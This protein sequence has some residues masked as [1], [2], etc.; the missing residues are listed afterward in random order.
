MP[1]Y[2]S[3]GSSGINNS[4]K[5]NGH[6]NTVNY[7]NHNISSPQS[8]IINSNINS[9]TQVNNAE[10]YYSA[11]NNA[12]QEVVAEKKEDIKDKSTTEKIL[13]WLNDNI[14][15]PSNEV[16]TQNTEVDRQIAEQTAGTVTAVTVSAVEGIVDAF[17]GMM[18]T[19]AKLGEYTML[20]AQQEVERQLA[21]D[22]ALGKISVEER[23][24][25]SAK[26]AQE[27]SE[28]RQE[29]HDYVQDSAQRV[30]NFKS[31][32]IFDVKIPGTETT[33][34]EYIIEYS[35]IQEDSFA[36]QVGQSIGQMIP[37]IVSNTLIPGSGTAVFATSCFGKS[38]SAAY[39]N[40]ANEEEAL[41]YAALTTTVEV[42][43][44]LIPGNGF[45]GVN[46]I[47]KIADNNL[48]K[49]VKNISN[50]ETV[51]KVVN[52][53]FTQFIFNAASEGVEEVISDFAEPFILKVS[54]LKEEDL[55]NLITES[56][57]LE[58]FAT[59]FLL[60]AASSAGL[61]SLSTATSIVSNSK[62]GE[63]NNISKKDL[64]E[65]YDEVPDSVKEIIEKT[66]QRMLEDLNDSTKVS[67]D[68]INQSINEIAK[69]GGIISSIF[70]NKITTSNNSNQNSPSM[71]I[72]NKVEELSN[73][74]SNRFST[75]NN[76]FIIDS[77]GN[78]VLNTSFTAYPTQYENIYIKEGTNTFYY[79]DG[80]SLP[81]PFRSVID[82]S[83]L[84]MVDTY[85]FKSKGKVD[86]YLYRISEKGIIQLKDPNCEGELTYNSNDG[87]YKSI[88]SQQEYYYDPRGILLPKSIPNY[89]NFNLIDEKLIY[90][91]GKIYNETTKEE[92]FISSDL[93]SLTDA[94]GRTIMYTN[95]NQID[96]LNLNNMVM[97]SCLNQ[98]VEF[99]RLVDAIM[100][101]NPRF[102][103]QVTDKSG[104]CNNHFVNIDYDDVNL[105][106]TSTNFHEWG[107]ALLKNCVS[108]F[109]EKAFSFFDFI[110]NYRNN[111][112][113]E[114]QNYIYNQLTELNN[115]VY[116]RCIEQAE[117][118]AKKLGI[119]LNS[120][121]V[122][123]MTDALF[124]ETGI[125]AL[126]DIFEAVY[127]QRIQYG[128]GFSYWDKVSY[129]DK[130]DLDENGKPQKKYVNGTKY[131]KSESRFHECF[132]NYTALK[133]SNNHVGLNIM[134]QLIGT[135][136]FQLI[137]NTYNEG[138][139]PSNYNANII[140]TT[141]D[142]SVES[143]KNYYEAYFVD[144]VYNLY[145]YFNKNFTALDEAFNNYLNKDDLSYIPD[146][147][148]S[149]YILSNVIGVKGWI[150]DYYNTAIE[151]LKKETTTEIT[152]ELISTIEETTTELIER[153]DMAIAN[154]FN[155]IINTMKGKYPDYWRDNL[156]K[157]IAS[158]ASG[159]I[160][161][162][163]ITRENDCRTLIQKMPI[164]IFLEQYSK[165]ISKEVRMTEISFQII[166]NSM[167]ERF[168]DTWKNQFKVF[169]KSV[170][171]GIPHYEYIT[172]MNDSRNL[173]QNIEFPT[174]LRLYN[175]NISGENINIIALSDLQKQVLSCYQ[176]EQFK[177]N[178]IIFWEYQ[179]NVKYRRDYE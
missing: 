74:F 34:R 22:A 139:N 142:N 127:G 62:T 99:Q 148:N 37:V 38:L 178:L 54:Y 118:N 9:N 117:N 149:H 40:G 14:F 116:E 57:T 167:Q 71:N 161:Y 100:Q 176:D 168:P 91:N 126:T 152:E 143:N 137:E 4:V 162:D 113:F 51:K 163:Y 45:G 165:M 94:Q 15:E 82:G 144:V 50:N 157:F 150:K 33:I 69:T 158:Y 154:D 89:K 31:K 101:M 8:Y 92:Y 132:A 97:D 53:Y 93:G 160:R 112:S 77:N 155:T 47:G 70:K 79:Y 43:I 130:I 23:Q 27:Y 24:K 18:T 41:I 119:N 29:M 90:N 48:Y 39:A 25:Q 35:I 125:V 63:N 166:I 1:N 19:G 122:G 145:V 44:E 86:P 95:L 105:N 111:L 115:S 28:A 65:T 124:R 72:N 138:L 151:E 46:K 81:V 133:M 56:Y 146:I 98:N 123:K 80:K 107:H 85:H 175:E 179:N 159:Q 84:E 134:E 141:R 103:L 67:K 73:Y 36:W 30:E 58:N 110:N 96:G 102:K 147:E 106:I 131:T 60:G 20:G 75:K 136:A 21:E 128:H 68:K 87:S 135:E 26:Y 83:N 109:K 177:N 172:S 16:R 171:D 7:S 32:Y 49:I 11:E 17:N 52:S 129:E 3:V 42:A 170:N 156:E 6:K 10:I 140:I 76:N 120:E 164:E 173:I 59:D 114:Q 104:Y 153:L 64:Q 12:P 108:H 88:Y 55:S 5:F 61:Q 174:L 2:G 13:Q 169:I 66:D 78:L 121:E